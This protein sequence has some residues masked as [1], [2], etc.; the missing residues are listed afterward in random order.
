MGNS[1]ACNSPRTGGAVSASC[2]VEAGDA[3]RCMMVRARHHDLVVVGRA[4]TGGASKAD[5]FI[6]PFSELRGTCLPLRRALVF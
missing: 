1:S 3:E 6:T 4:R 2:R 5:S